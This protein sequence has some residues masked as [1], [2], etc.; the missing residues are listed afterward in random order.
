MVKGHEE[1]VENAKFYLS[2]DDIDNT[3]TENETG[4]GGARAFTSANKNT[5][6]SAITSKTKDVFLTFSNSHLH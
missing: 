6:V 1:H 3:I 4:F 2:L 5:Y